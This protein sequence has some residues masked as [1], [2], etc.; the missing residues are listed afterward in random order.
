MSKARRINIIADMF[1]DEKIKIID[2]LPER[3]TILVIWLKI[4]TLAGKCNKDGQ[5]ILS[6]NIGYN[7]E[8]L[9]VLFDRP[10]DSIKMAME[11]FKKLKMINTTI[12]PDGNT[13]YMITNWNKYQ[14][15]KAYLR[16]KQA[17]YR[18]RQRLQRLE[19][20]DLYNCQQ[21]VNNMSTNRKQ[22]VNI[23]STLC[24]QSVN[25]MSTN[26][27]IHNKINELDNV[28]NFNKETNML[29]CDAEIQD[30]LQNIYPDIDI[31]E[32]LKEISAW[33]TAHDEINKDGNFMRFVIKLLNNNKKIKKAKTISFNPDTASF[34]GTDDN[35]INILKSKFLGIDVDAEIKKMESWLLNNPSRRP[36][37]NYTR[38]INSWLTRAQDKASI[39]HSSSSQQT[40]AERKLQNTL[41]AMEEVKRDLLKGGNNE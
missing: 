31:S 10:I 18:E 33:L 21:S 29:E 25:K 37:K 4:L 12:T 5:L 14:G 2:S 6:N 34:V 40:F 28:I 11:T 8:M 16:M 27:D 17:E 22:N 35:Y 7:E 30:R 3:D 19:S 13:I 41:K 20:N 23:M 36:A 32:K 9:S 26:Y 38:F 39:R 15:R 1:N 24:Q